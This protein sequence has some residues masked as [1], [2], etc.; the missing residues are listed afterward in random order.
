[1][2]SQ[3]VVEDANND[4]PICE[5]IEGWTGNAC[6]LRKDKQLPVK[7]LPYWFPKDAIGTEHTCDRI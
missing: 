4:S 2:S 6:H 1:M 7:P 5:C 3:L